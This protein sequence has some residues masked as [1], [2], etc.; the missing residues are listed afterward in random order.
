MLVNVQMLDAN[1]SWGAVFERMKKLQ[2]ES[3]A[4]YSYVVTATPND[5]VYNTIISHES[6]CGT[7]SD[8]QDSCC[9][10]FLLPRKP[11]AVPTQEAM[12]TLIPFERRFLKYQDL[13]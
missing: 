7:A 1:L 13:P 6:G 10:K 2:A 9:C 3:S 8:D 5:C 11:K 12:K 4:V